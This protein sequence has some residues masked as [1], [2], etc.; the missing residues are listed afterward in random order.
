MLFRRIAALLFVLQFSAL[1]QRQAGDI[2]NR[3][4]GLKGQVVITN[5][6]E[7]GR[8]PASGLYF[9]LQRSGCRDCLIGVRTDSEGRYNLNIGAGKYRLYCQDT[10]LTDLVRRGQPREVTVRSGLQDTEFNIELEL[11]SKR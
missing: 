2:Y 6:Q 1:A 4:G 10:D 5:H 7:L 3:I 11:P 9:V 8:T